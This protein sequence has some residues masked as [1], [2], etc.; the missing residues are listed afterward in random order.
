MKGRINFD[1]TLILILVLSIVAVPAN[2][3]ELTVGLYP[4]VPRLEQFQTAIKTQWAKVQP[5]VTLK[6]LAAA[7]WDGGYSN[8]PPK[9]ADVYVFDAMFFDYFQS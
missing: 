2:G 8:N 5:Q 6:F 9:N 1:N 3:T 7:D 4:Y